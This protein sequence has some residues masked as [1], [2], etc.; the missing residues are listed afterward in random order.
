MRRT[1]WLAMATLKGMAG[2]ESYIRERIEVDHETHEQVSQALQQQYPGTTGLS[3]RNIRRYCCD[4][5]IH[6]TSRF[7]WSELSRVVGTAVSQVQF[8]NVVLY[9]SPNYNV[10]PLIYQVHY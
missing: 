4:N 1:N 6:A 9:P 3:S 7:S 5:N 2:V 8:S 10:P